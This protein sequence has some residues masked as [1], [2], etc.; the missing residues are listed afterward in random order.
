MLAGNAPA[1]PHDLH[2]LPRLGL[3]CRQRLLAQHVLAGLQRR[4]DACG[5]AAGL[6]HRMPRA[7]A[8]R[9]QSLPERPT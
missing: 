1:A 6:L 2:D 4:A 8:I 5:D 3:V 9:R 7:D